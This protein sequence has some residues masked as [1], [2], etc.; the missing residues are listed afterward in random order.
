M[1][2][3][4]RICIVAGRFGDCKE[5]QWSYNQGNWC[6]NPKYDSLKLPVSIF[7][8]DRR[9]SLLTYPSQGGSQKTSKDRTGRNTCGIPTID[10]AN[11]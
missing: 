9:G 2:H 10:Q 8:P 4:E 5:K 11:A 6:L 3:V 1:F 7:G